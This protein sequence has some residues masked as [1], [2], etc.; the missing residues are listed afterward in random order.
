[1]MQ[2]DHTRQER[3]TG[4]LFGN[5]FAAY[6]DEAFKRSVG[7]FEARFKEVGFDTEWFRGKKCLD[8]GCGGGR[9][10]IALAHLGAGQVTGVDLSEMGIADARERAAQLGAEHVCFKVGS[11]AQLPFDDATFDCVIHSGVLQHTAD[12]VK[13]VNE[14]SRV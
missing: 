9:Y 3:A 2:D 1:M 10:S 5:L 13:V 11:V 4:R 12:P 8:A 14:L 6:D 7:L